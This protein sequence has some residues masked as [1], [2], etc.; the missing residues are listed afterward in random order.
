MQPVRCE[1]QRWSTQPTSFW[2]AD[3]TP[4]LW[5]I[6]KWEVDHNKDSRISEFSKFRLPEVLSRFLEL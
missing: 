3:H 6:R 1:G 5:W 4:M 2:N